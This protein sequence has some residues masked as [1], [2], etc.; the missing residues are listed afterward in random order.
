MCRPTCIG[1]FAFNH[2]TWMARGALAELASHAVQ[3]ERTLCSVK[4]D[5]SSLPLSE[6]PHAICAALR[7]RGVNV[8]LYCGR[9]RT[10]RQRAAQSKLLLGCILAR[11]HVV[12]ASACQEMLSDQ[13]RLKRRASEA[14]VLLL[15]VGVDLSTCA[16]ARVARLLDTSA[17]PR[18]ARAERLAL[19]H[20]GFHASSGAP[21]WLW[22]A[23]LGRA[24][25]AA[26]RHGRNAGAVVERGRLRRVSLQRGGRAIPPLAEFGVERGT[27][28]S[29]G[30]GADVVALALG[31][32]SV[33][34]SAPS[35]GGAPVAGG[36][37]S[38]GGVGAAADAWA[39]DIAVWW[40]TRPRADICAR[41]F[42]WLWSLLTAIAATRLVGV[43]VHPQVSFLLPLLFA[44][45]LLTV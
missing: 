38:G 20:V 29:A 2:S 35:G 36:T 8:L 19:L 14:G 28:A 39:D 24:A 18:G 21:P 33:Y 43:I 31:A 30:P 22:D 26:R 11:V 15:P 16:A 7:S 34:G 13:W 23:A 6:A 10:P 37:A 44:R 40:S 5:A 3:H 41:V 17:P 32:R 25:E 45:I 12:D 1:L 4:L 27:L 42:G 9:S